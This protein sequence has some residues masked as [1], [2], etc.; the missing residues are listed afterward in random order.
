[1]FKIVAYIVAKTMSMKEVLQKILIPVVC[2]LPIGASAQSG[3]VRFS[4]ESKLSINGKSNVNDFRCLSNHDLR[5]DSLNFTYEYTGNNIQVSN[6]KLNLEVDQFDCGKKGINRD[7]RNS[8]KYQEYP[9]IQITLNEVILEDS[10][11]LSPTSANLTIEIAGVEQTYSVPLSEF[12]R[13]ENQV[14]VEGSKVLHMTDF[15]IEPPF[16]LFGLVQVSNELNIVF[17]LVI[18]LGE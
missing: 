2:A 3:E 9:F 16:A 5:Q 8:L 11:D 13:D 6:I 4:N 15:N 10:E 18:K 1:M 7:F 12:S 17:D 14:L